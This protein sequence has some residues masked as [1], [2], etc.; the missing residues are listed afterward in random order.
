MSEYKFVDNSPVLAV[1]IIVKIKDK[2]L[3]IKRKYPPLGYALPGGHVEKGES[4]LDAAKR[5]LKEE[6][7]LDATFS[8]QFHTYSKPDRDPRRHVVSVV[9][10]AESFGTPKAADD[11]AEI[12]LMTYTETLITDLVFD[13]SRIITDFIIWEK[14]NIEPPYY[15]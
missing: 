5:E 11:A 4:L 2:I 8:R 9:F 10:I 1:D 6:T 7:R 3:F 12:K 15:R 13:H 14:Y